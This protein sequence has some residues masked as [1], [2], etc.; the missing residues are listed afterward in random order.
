MSEYLPYGGFKWVKVN[1]ETVNRVLNKSDNSLHGYF[2]EVGQDYPEKLHDY[3]K[4]FPMA[5]EKIKIKDEMLSLYQLEIKKENDIKVGGI[6]K[7]IPNLL[8]KKNYVVHNRNLKYYLS[9]GLIL[10]MVHRILEFKQ[11]AWMKP[12]N[13][14]NTRKRKEATNEADKNLFK[15]LNSAVYEKTMENMRKRIKIRI[16][17]NEKDFLKYTSRPTYIGHKKFDKNLVVIYQKK[18]LLTLNKP[19]CV[20]CTVSELS[21]LAMYKFYYHNFIILLFY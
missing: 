8:P 10:K 2:L 14:F 4:D 6:N 20:G 1:N 11:S 21:K 19:V 18:E 3:H 16:T 17:I 9:Q 5:P 13:D 12:Y 7:L 15:L